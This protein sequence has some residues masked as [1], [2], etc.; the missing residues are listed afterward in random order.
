MKG[1]RSI[2][3]IDDERD[4][5]D[6]LKAELQG[7]LRVNLANGGSEG[8]AQ[9]AKEHC[10]LVLTDVRMAGIDGI[11]VL[12]TIKQM[13]P[14]CEV[15]LMSG[16]S[17]LDAVTAAMNE[18]A[19]AFVTKP[20]SKP[21]LI[22]RIDHAIAVIQGRENQQDVLRELKHNLLMQSRFAHRLSTLAA[23]SGGI[24]HELQQPL[25]GIGMYS[26]TVRKMV[27]QGRE[28]EPE[29]L[30][31]TMGKIEKQVDRAKS[32]I[33]HMREYSSGKQQ[34]ETQR[35]KLCDAVTRALELFKLQLQSH[36]IELTVEIPEDLEIFADQYRFEQVIV[37]LVSNAKDGILSSSAG[38][39][40]GGPRRIK[41]NGRREDGEILIDVKD[42][43]C[44]VPLSLTDSLFD[45]FVTSKADS[46]GSGL[47]LYICRSVL[48]DFTAGIQLVATDE[49]GST[50]RLNFPIV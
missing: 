8:I 15:L 16:Y 46:G 26:A 29:F 2:L 25:S 34:L 39:V 41:I 7:K 19:F 17:D 27:E 21:M 49:T 31:E 13:A 11:Q 47:G 35:L 14:L 45:P 37:N 32:V 40:N 5:L 23:M 10:D 18:G 36:K 42:T 30:A 12:K 3:I 44:G 43:G 38:P 28:I 1:K 48:E 22:N 33:D 24:A 50:F 20:I 9:F 4:N 6:Y